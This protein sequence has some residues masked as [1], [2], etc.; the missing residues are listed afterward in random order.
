MRNPMGR[1][2]GW[3]SSTSLRLIVNIVV[4]KCSCVN[5]LGSYSEIH[6][7]ID[8]LAADGLVCQQSEYWTNPLTTS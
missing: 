8:I 7:R 5:Q 2:Q 3:N 4:N 1:V 6:H